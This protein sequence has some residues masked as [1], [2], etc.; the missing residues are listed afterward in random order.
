MAGAWG[1]GNFGAMSHDSS[2][3]SKVISITDAARSHILELRNAEP[4]GDRLGIRLE[5][6]TDT[7]PDFTY[8]LSFQV[9]TK[10]AFTDSVQ[11]HDGLRTVIPEKDMVNLQGA[12]LDWEEGGLVLRNPNKPKPFT[13]EGLVVDDELSAKIRGLLDAEINPA[14]DSHGG[15]VTYVGHDE[16]LAAYLSMGGGCQGCSMSRMTMVEGVQKSLVTAFP[17]IPKVV[18]VTDHAAG[19]TPYYAG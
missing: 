7:G 3:D 11:N 9:V 17:E 13:M 4:D 8:D 14:L 12:V 2:P 19:A 15:F 6:L 5:I 16:E 18:D 1:G 10:A